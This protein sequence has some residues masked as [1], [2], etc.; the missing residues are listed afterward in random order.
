MVLIHAG[1]ITIVVMLVL[2]ASALEILYSLV[3]GTYDY[4]ASQ[5]GCTYTLRSDGTHFGPQIDLKTASSMVDQSQCLDINDGITPYRGIC[6]RH[7]MDSR[8]VILRLLY[9]STKI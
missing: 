1:R 7:S 2:C 3:M 8:S 9:V 6:L 5:R 4:K